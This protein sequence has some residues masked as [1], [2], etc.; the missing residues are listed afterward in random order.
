MQ[1]QQHRKM[2]IVESLA[3]LP[4]HSPGYDENKFNTLTVAVP[5]TGKLLPDSLRI[6]YLF[7]LATSGKTPNRDNPPRLR[8]K[9]TILY[10]HGNASDIGNLEWY[11]RELAMK[12]GVNFV[13]V[14]Y[15]GYGHAK[16]LQLRGERRQ[17]Q[18]TPSEKWTYFALQAML[19]ELHVMWRIEES[20]VILMG[21]SIGSGPAVEFACRDDAK[22]RG[23]VLDSAFT[24]CVR[25]KLRLPPGVKW[26]SDKLLDIYQNINKLPEVKCK[27]LV[28]HGDQDGVVPLVHSE[29]NWDAIPEVF[30][31]KK[32]IV[33]DAMH[34]D[35]EFLR[36][37]RGGVRFPAE[38]A[39]EYS[40]V[41]A[42]F[43]REVSDN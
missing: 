5:E 25:I 26:V 37:S 38:I 23:L 16:Y 30:R 28:I 33:P 34:N 7:Y 21:K 39:P 27:V 6:P 14:E 4:P 13:A 1:P 40:G 15:P 24:S 42:E 22:F 41:I 18:I 31:W 10:C 35:I 11:G 20:D 36:D 17:T 12:C 19:D 8:T 32:M 9:T 29:E 3:F 43:V 2:G